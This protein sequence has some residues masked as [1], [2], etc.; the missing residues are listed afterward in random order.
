M[1]NTVAPTKTV[2]DFNSEKAKSGIYN[3]KS[4]VKNA[5]NHA[6]DQTENA[7]ATVKQTYHDAK[8]AARQNL[9]Y[10]EQ[11]IRDRPVQA[12]LVAAGV[13]FL[14]ATLLIR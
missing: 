14:V 9:G 10:I 4:T 2:K 12:T 3:A 13:G 5:A 8:D 6:G 11:Q 7:V 1:S